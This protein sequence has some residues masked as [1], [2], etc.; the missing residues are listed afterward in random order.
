MLAVT[1]QEPGR[2]AIDL[3]FNLLRTGWANGDFDYSGLIDFDDYVLI[4]IAYNTQNGTLARAIAYLDGTDRSASGRARTGVQKVVEH[5]AEFGA[6][7][8][9]E[10]L[11]AVPEPVP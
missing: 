7:Y 6:E 8:A 4:D 1:F 9:N 3:G 11:A 5:F 10:F 2:V